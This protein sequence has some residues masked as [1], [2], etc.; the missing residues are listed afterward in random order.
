MNAESIFKGAISIVGVVQLL[1]NFIPIKA[2]WVWTIF[3]ILVGIGI[4]ALQYLSPTWVMD[5][6]IT[7]SGASL[8]YDT[9]YQ[10]FEKLFKR[11]S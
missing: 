5:A 11:E 3:T 1:K 9:I 4:S 6:I 10:T 2:G 8:F 7:I